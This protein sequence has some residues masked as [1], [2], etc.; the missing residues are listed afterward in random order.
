MTYSV[1]GAPAVGFDLARLPGGARVA[2]V[3]RTALTADA[4]AVAALSSCHPG[5]VRASWW[6]ACTRVPADSLQDVL[7]AVAPALGDTAASGALL[8]RLESG[9]LGDLDALDRLVRHDLLDWTWI[10]AGAVS[11][12]DPVAADAA[13]VL[14]DAAVAAFAGDEVDATTRRAMTVPFLS[15]RPGIRDESVPVGVEDVDA[16]LDRLARADDRTRAAWRAVVDDRR[17]STA[18]WAPAMHQATWALAVAERLRPA[19]D[20]QMA[21]V[22]AFARAGFTAHDAAYGVWNA[23]SGV[24]QASMVGDLL[25][26]ADADVLL[27]PWRAVHGD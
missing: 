12:Q 3:L 17:R 25:P 11:T 22:A 2:S 5:P 19:F 27:A 4:S 13:D 7:P 1:V 26:A 24:V 16:R 10:H 14:V 20:A 9:L 18:Q 6:H 8:H 21:A 23:V 15:A